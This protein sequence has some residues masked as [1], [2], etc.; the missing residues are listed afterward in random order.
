[1]ASTPV[2]V[3][4]RGSKRPFRAPTKALLY[5][6]PAAVVYGFFA[7]WSGLTTVYLSF[8]EWDGLQTPGFV[9]LANYLNVFSDPKLYGSIVHALVLIIFFSMIPVMLGLILTALLMGRVRKGMTF[10]RTVFFLPQ[11]LPLVAVGITWRW[12]FA[13][14]GLVNQF[15]NG[16]GLGAITRAW[17]GDH[18]LALIALGIIGTWCMT[19]LCMVLFLSGAQK[20]DPALYEAATIDGAGAV[21]RFFSITIPGLR[22]E[23]TVA[24][25]ITTIA[26]LASFD[27]VY[28]TTDGGPANQT[29]VPG[30]LVYRLAF[31]QNDIGNASAIAVVLTIL[32]IIIV[33]LIRALFKEET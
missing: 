24:T 28:V 19:G 9:G 30:L 33:S 8:F 14:N 25:V 1:M 17:L 26:A 31:N 27:L 5:I 15:L 16:I 29:T 22:G 10:F 12:M 7:V 3:R 18:S 4:G 23:V 32:V 6:L 11:V 2:P 13:E 21:R 20:I